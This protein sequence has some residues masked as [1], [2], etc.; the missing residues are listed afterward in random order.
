MWLAWDRQVA[1]L[2][3]GLIAVPVRTRRAGLLFSDNTFHNR[4]MTNQGGILGRG[5]QCILKRISNHLCRNAKMR[6][7]QDIKL[8]AHHELGA[9]IDGARMELE[10]RRALRTPALLQSSFAA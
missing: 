4:S 7:R 2:S 1:R 10:G 6:Q 9:M 8:L 3:D 5:Q